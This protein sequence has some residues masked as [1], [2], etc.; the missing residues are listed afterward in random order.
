MSLPFFN[1]H[2]QAPCAVDLLKS[3]THSSSS[4]RLYVLN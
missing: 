2:L 3:L 1:Q 4:E